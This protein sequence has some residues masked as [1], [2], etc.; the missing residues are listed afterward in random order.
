MAAGAG[1]AHAI[2]PT[3]PAAPPAWPAARAN[4]GARPAPVA[5]A[6]RHRRIRA[7]GDVLHRGAV[8]RAGLDDQRHA[9][10]A[11]VDHARLAV[12]ARGP[13]RGAGR[14]RPAHRA[15]RRLGCTTPGSGAARAARRAGDA[16][17]LHVRARR[18]HP[19]RHRRARRQPGLPVQRAAAGLDRL[20]SRRR[21]RAG[22]GALPQL[23]PRLSASGNELRGA[24]RVLPRPRAQRMRR[25]PP[26]RAAGHPA[27]A[28]RR[29][30][31]R[32]GI[33][34]G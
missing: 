2:A 15:A 3:P 12:H 4:L 23:R 27:R 30:R 33:R 1:W 26:G 9:S 29:P 6:G 5:A 17:R 34:A 25:R 13:C 14:R 28:V 7:T 31:V 11:G 20:R 24:G 22:L 19:P 32:R 21:R 16:L 18:R 10:A 8:A